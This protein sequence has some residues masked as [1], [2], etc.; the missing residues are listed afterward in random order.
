MTLIGGEAYLCEDWDIIATAITK[1]GMACTMTTGGRGM[2]EECVQR[3]E[4]A[5]L[6]HISFRLMDS[7]KPMMHSVECQ[8]LGM[9]RLKVPSVW[10]R[11]AWG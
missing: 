1:S 6:K 5:G 11:V 7:S 8:D 10:V 2:N 4:D 3:A 9:L